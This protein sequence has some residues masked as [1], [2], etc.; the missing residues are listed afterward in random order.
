[1]TKRVYL[2]VDK[3]TRDGALQL[4]IGLED[5]YGYRIAGPK[6]DGDGKTLVRHFLTERDVVEIQ[7]F[8]K[9]VRP[10]APEIP[11]M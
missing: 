8:L 7:N 3:R 6:Y 11:A 2:S 5:S 4:S 10:S 1:M 9:K